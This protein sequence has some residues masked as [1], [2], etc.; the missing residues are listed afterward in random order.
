MFATIYCLLYGAHHDLHRRLLNSLFSR[1]PHD[2]ARVVVWCNAVC[3]ET[4]QWF[5]QHVRTDWDVIFSDE[6]VPKYRAMRRMFHEVHQPATSWVVWFDDDS[7]IE[8]DDWW[9]RTRKYIADHESE[10]ICYIG[11]PWYVHHLPGQEEFIRAAS[12]YTGKPW[13][14]CAT[15]RPGIVK[16]GISF[17]Q[18]AYWW[19]R[20]DV[21]KEL[22]WPDP[23]LNHN[24]GDT[25]LGEAIRQQ[26]LPFH[27]FRYGVKINDAKRRGFH[28]RPAGSKVNTR[29]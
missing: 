17:A 21:M 28:E 27:R 2:T 10:A 13:E 25:L 9:E 6:N 16:P 5:K 11:Q 29:R 8:A 24:G 7:W 14:L 23:R 3:K 1:L 20:T 26:G 22:D 18:G 12:W 15:R 19:L 4:R